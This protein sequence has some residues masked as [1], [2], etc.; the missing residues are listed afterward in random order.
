M[1]SS[2]QIVV[3]CLLSMTVPAFASN[4]IYRYTD[5]SGTLNF[6]TELY[7]IPEKYRSEAVPLEPEASPPV[8]SLKPVQQP[9]LR[10]VTSTGE[11]RMGDHDTRIDATRM[12]I[13]DA[14]RQALEQVATYLES[15]T[16]VR[17][18]DVTRD[19]IRTYTAG[20]V[21]VLNQQTSTRLED[22]A[23]V[24]HVD[25]T[26]QVDEHEVVQA[27]ASLREN[28]SAKQELLSLR[29]GID[30][31]REQLDAANQALATANTPE[32][33]QALTVQR[34]QLLNRMQADALV[35]QAK[36]KTAAL[37]TETDFPSSLARLRR[38]LSGGIQ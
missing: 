17:N 27:I 20:I 16:E 24:I 32:Q 11:Y 33:V 14:E 8:E 2:S 15:V 6:T 38:F 13:E 22:G 35:A 5:D 23:I 21:M 1:A 30:Q 7:S 31:L 36:T 9:V 10:V 12:A 26:A 29:A 37:T 28:E 25:L 18:L 3:F 34:K 19:E 4:Q